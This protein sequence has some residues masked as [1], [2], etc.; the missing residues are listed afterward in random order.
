[1]SQEDTSALAPL[2]NRAFAWLWLGVLVSSIGAWAQTVGAQWLF[3]N[4]PNGA[5]IVSLVQT[6]TMLPMML[7]ALPGGV[8][9]DAFDRRGLLLGI[10][11]YF[12]VV[13][14]SLAVLAALGQVPP[15]LLLAFTFA[16][17]MGTALQLPTWQPLITELV[18]RAQIPAATRLD[19]VNVNVS[20]AAGPAIAGGIIA[21]WGVPP[22][23]FFNAACVAVLALVLLLWR[24]PSTT[25]NSGS[26]ER[27]L[28][29]LRAG[30]RY[31]R[32]EPVV[33][34]IFVRLALFVMPAAAMWA[35]LPILASRQL[36]LPA[37][38]YGLLFVALGV[39]AVSA[40]LGL[41]RVRAR[42]SANAVLTLSTLLF[43]AAFALTM[44]APGLWLAGPLLVLVGFG[45]TAVASTLMA[46]LQLFLPGWVRARALA[47]N[48]MVFAGTQALAAPLWGLVTQYAGLPVAV[49]LSAGLLALVAAAGLRM[50]LPQGRPADPSPA[51]YW[52][53]PTLGFEP[54]PDAGPVQVMIS[55]EVPPADQG[56]WL[57]AMQDVRRS[58]LRSGAFRWELYRVGER[59][60]H[61][62][63]I[64]AVPSWE[65]HEHQHR[66]RL[67]AD[68][69]AVEAAALAFAVGTPTG[70]HLLPPEVGR[71]TDPPFG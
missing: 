62:V 27:F 36:G 67:T 56:S 45:W 24:R 12:V 55:Y 37:S 50:P 68:D 38:G 71:R 16:I 41:G 28:P 4:D 15:V 48:L 39:G 13:A 5:T 47:A 34:L 70:E 19:M 43:A 30:G 8:L 6:A 22:V 18:P 42:L 59:P 26:R 57:A 9:A 31:V 69:R 21:A 61:F 35:L 23:F 29:A 63:E 33:R 54:E 10:Q 20:R 66:S 3:V 40:A 25:E 11:C 2:K 14:L 1:M 64:F 32:H 58:R 46:E 53:E 49:Y 17:G 65:E 44:V 52:G 7:L 60:D 51:L